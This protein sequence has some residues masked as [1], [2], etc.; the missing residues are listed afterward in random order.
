M[1]SW[2]DKSVH[3]VG[4]KGTGMA[5]LAELLVAAGARV[6]GSD[7]PEKFF[8]DEILDAAG[9]PYAESFDASHL[10]PA[11]DLVIHSAAYSPDT[12][13]ELIEAGRL[14]LPVQVYPE[15][16]GTFSEGFARAAG[17]AGVHGKTTTTALA[18]VVARALGLPASVLAG[19]VVPDFG[20][21]ATLNLGGDL[22]IAETC[23]YK[24]HFMHFHPSAVLVTS[25]ELDHTDYFTDY[26]DIFR[27]FFDY[28]SKLPRG[29][30]FVY[31]ADETGA[32]SLASSLRRH[33]P[34]LSFVPYGLRAEGAFR[35]V[36]R[37]FA[38]G[39]SRFRLEGFAPALALRVPGTHNVLNAAGACALVFSLAQRTITEAELTSV[40]AALASFKG[41][42]RRSQLVGEA[43]GVLVM[44]DYGHHP[45]AVDLTLR[46]IKDFFPDRRLV[47]DFMS[48]T[49]SRTKTLLDEFAHAFSAADE[50]VLHKIYASA[51]ERDTLGIDGRTLYDATA[52]AHPRVS[53]FDEVADAVPY[54]LDTLR[55]GDLLVTM[56]AGDNWKAGQAFLAART[57][58]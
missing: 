42:R 58:V 30:L 48:H 13:P 46:G 51:R 43:G 56:G 20:N 17:I 34:D 24:R 26:D 41:S 53:Y 39:E 25:V 6:R 52:K 15:A 29:G 37:S 50:V 38:P 23:E 36:D 47:V 31:C 9:V 19:S 35:V 49:Y 21:R 11:P 22:F 18:G 57:S 14:G 7:I 28:A 4:V 2:K 45:T 33:P 3:M 32:A 44:D 27:A 54:Y 55:P 10:A 8:T 1:Q 16:L 5:A 40:G 12:N